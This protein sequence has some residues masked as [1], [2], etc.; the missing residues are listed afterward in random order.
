VTKNSIRIYEDKSKALASHS[1]PLI[2]IPLSAV[3][4]V[5]RTKFDINDDQRMERADIR[6]F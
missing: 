4:K 3:K 5:E 2:A 6:T 1:K